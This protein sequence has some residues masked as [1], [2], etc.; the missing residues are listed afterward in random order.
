MKQLK[1]NE[2][3]DIYFEVPDG[4][5]DL[6][7]LLWKNNAFSIQLWGMEKMGPIPRETKINAWKNQTA[8]NWILPVKDITFV[9]KDLGIVA[10]A[11]NKGSA[12]LLLFNSTNDQFHMAYLGFS[13]PMQRQITDQIKIH[14][15]SRKTDV[16]LT[17]L[18]S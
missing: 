1:V 13:Q 5:E 12:G 9:T 10:I 17:T 11:P 2:T 18:L 8:K 16:T 3:D 14:C 4:M 15:V 7:N 6:K